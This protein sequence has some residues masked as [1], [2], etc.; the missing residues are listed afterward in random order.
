MKSIFLRLY[1]AQDIASETEKAV[2]GYLLKN[3]ED[4][5]NLNV[6]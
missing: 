3:P 4:V 2:I 1:E 6:R 5:M